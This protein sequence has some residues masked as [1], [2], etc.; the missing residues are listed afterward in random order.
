MKA[1]ITGASSGLGKE[2]AN[3]LSNMGYDLILVARRKKKL[4]SLK[5]KLKTNITIIDMDIS[6]SYN[7]IKLYEQVKNEDI[8]I[9]INNAGFGLFGDFISTNIEKELDMIDLN[10]KAVHILTKLF[11][12]DFKKKNK[13]YILNVASTAAFQPG[14]LMSVYYATKSYVFNL[15]HAI[16]KELKKEGSHIYIGTLCPGPVETEFN[17]V[18]GV[19]FSVKSLTSNYVCNYAIKKMFKNKSIILPGMSAKTVYY[20]GRFAPLNL[21][22]NIAYNIQKSKKG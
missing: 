14:P 8:D 5:N 12:K 16:R 17:K 22:L 18:A 13:G 4:E 19:K 9:L 21:K 15:T 11:L 3:I 1:L 7:C 6:S 20:L 2:F 10:I